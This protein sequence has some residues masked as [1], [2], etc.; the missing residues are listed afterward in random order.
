M[1]DWVGAHSGAGDARDSKKNDPLR[2]NSSFADPNKRCMLV[3][4]QI[5]LRLL[6]KL[7]H[8]VMEAADGMFALERYEDSLYT[9]EPFHAIFMDFV[10][11]NMDGE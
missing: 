11:P 1:G 9:N 4:A 2:T 10:M 6:K 5:I 7:G 3:I 8:S